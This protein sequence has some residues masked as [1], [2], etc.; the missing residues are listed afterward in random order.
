[1]GLEIPLPNDHPLTYCM[2]ESDWAVCEK[3]ISDLQ[4]V[5]DTITNTLDTLKVDNA[6]LKE[7]ISIMKSTVDSINKKVSNMEIQYASRTSSNKWVERLIWGI[8]GCVLTAAITIML[9][10]QI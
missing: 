5:T 6:I 3:N 9:K 2:H 1:M 7:N 4:K 8:V 10:G